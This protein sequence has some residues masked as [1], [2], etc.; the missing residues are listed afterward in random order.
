MIPNVLKS[1]KLTELKL[2]DI[3]EDARYSFSYPADPSVLFESVKKRGVISPVWVTPSSTDGAF[4]LIHG[5][6][7]I[8]AARKFQIETIMALVF[9]DHDPFELFLLGVEENA[10][11]RVLNQVEL[12]FIVSAAV[13]NF[14]KSFNELAEVLFPIL[15][16][17][18]SKNIYDR[19]LDLA[20]FGPASH[21]LI[22]K[23]KMPLGATVPLAGFGA[24]DRELICLWLT[25]NNFGLSKSVKLIEIVS[26]ICG[27]EKISANAVIND[28]EAKTP[29]DID[30]PQRAEK[31]FNNIMSRRNPTLADMQARF[32]SN[33]KDLK[34]P[35]GVTVIPPKNFEGKSL[36]FVIKAG[37]ARKAVDNA[38]AI[39]EAGKAKLSKLFDWI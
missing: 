8:T 5:F 28:A 37:D 32:A 24:D 15:G 2:E 21:A 10:V 27:I 11:S 35:A 3:K 9:E 36:D 4:N 23:L 17:S 34:L 29:V 20:R 30:P 16:L 12:S 7:R 39:S 25:K 38:R 26:E 14:G 19:L 13:E 18:K 6:R 31:L 33:V 22:A 1:V